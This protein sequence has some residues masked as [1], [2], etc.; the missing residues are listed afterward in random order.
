MLSL[1]VCLFVFLAS[2]CN[3]GFHECVFVQHGVILLCFFFQAMCVL[4]SSVVVAVLHSP[5]VPVC[6]FAD[7]GGVV[8]VPSG[9]Q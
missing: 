5:F 3:G 2:Y 9:V 8:G 1:F 6:L 4:S 7:K